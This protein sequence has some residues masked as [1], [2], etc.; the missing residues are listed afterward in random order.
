MTADAGEWLALVGPNGAGKSTLLHALAGL[1]PV[2]S[3]GAS[4]AGEDPGRARRRAMARAVALMP[5]RPVVPTGTTVEEFVS[6]GR[7]PHLG[8]FAVEGPADRAVVHDVL[9]RLDLGAFR[10]RTV[11]ELS[12]GELQRVVLARALAQRPRALLLDEPTSALDLGHAQQVLE[13]VDR[14]RV[15]DGITIVAAMHDLTFASQYSGRMVLLDE[16]RVVA[17]GKPR[18]VLDVDR[19]ADVYG[20]HVEIVDRG[21]GIVGILPVRRPR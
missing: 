14:L 8:R 4:V 16:G 21:D 9:D 15:D 2:A 3:G 6:L 18:D 1:L 10:R 11:T 19:M 13:L 17:D 12:G 5:Q 7:T 20:A